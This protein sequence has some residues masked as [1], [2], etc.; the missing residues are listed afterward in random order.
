[1]PPGTVPA[2]KTNELI[3][4]LTDVVRSG[5]SNEFEIRLIERDANKLMRSDPAGAHAVLGSVAAVHGD[6]EQTRDHYR[7]ALNLDNTPMLRYNHSVSLCLLEEHEEALKVAGEALAVYPSDLVLLDHAIKTALESANFAKAREFCDRWDVL[8][9]DRPNRVARSARQLADAVADGV[10][11]EEGVRELLRGVANIQRSERVL[12]SEAQVS[13][14]VA[15][16]SFLYMRNIYAAPELAAAMNERLA[17]FVAS[18]ADLMTDPGM[19]FVAAF[20]GVGAGGSN[21]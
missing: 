6:A 12:T 16:E 7:I 5:A 20:T 3:E 17:D 18:R 14:H 19:K 1:M 8:A 21:P 9:P 4:R 10:F 2:T 15:P 13:R 11:G